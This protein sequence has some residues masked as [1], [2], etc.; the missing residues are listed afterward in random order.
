MGKSQL[1]DALAE[2][3]RNIAAAEEA[4]AAI[5]PAELDSDSWLAVRA[6]IGRKLA[7]AD[8]AS[9]RVSEILGMSSAQGR[10]LAYFRNHVGDVLGKDELA[11][12]A[13]IHEWAR[14]VREL[15]KEHGWPIASGETRDDLSPGQYVLERDE[16]DAAL[17]GDWRTAN[18]I[19][20]LKA[21]GRPA[22]GKSRILEFLKAIYPRSADKEQLA[23]VAPDVHDRPRRLRELAEEGWQVVSS[24]DDSRLAP[25]EYRLDSLEQA[26]ARTRQAIKIRHQVFERDGFVCVDCGRA[27]RKDRVQLQAHHVVSVSKGGTNDDGNLVTLCTD[28]HAGRHAI[29][30]SK[31]EDELLNPAAEPRY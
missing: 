31:V 23:Y 22:S 21:G 16:A 12:V 27:P 11:G 26:P 19:R 2:T 17:A 15:R 14:R 3:R 4:L 5:D 1:A 29:E 25:G 28:C 10:L 20:R 8:H 24:V 18:Q 7:A 13:G 30:P 6:E 9:N